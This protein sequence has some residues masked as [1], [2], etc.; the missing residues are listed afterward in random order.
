[1]KKLSC[2]LLLYC[3]LNTILLL[4]PVMVYADINDEINHLLSYI[5]QSDCTYIRNGK[6]YTAMEAHDHIARK[7]ESVKRRIKTS[8]AFIQKIASSSSLSGKPYLIRC[9]EEEQTTEGWLYIELENYR[10]RHQ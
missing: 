6:N 4:S 3:L 9:E 8:E 2:L 1:M 7:Y 10:K 5:A